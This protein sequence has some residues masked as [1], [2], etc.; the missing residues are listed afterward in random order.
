MSETF[1]IPVR[2][3]IE[4]TDVGGIVYYVNYLK[5]M[6]RARTEL[7]RSLGYGK[8]AMPQAG[9]LMVV[10]SANIEYLKSAQLDDELQVTAHIARLGRA[11]VVFEQGVLRGEER[12]ATATVKVACIDAGSRKPTPLPKDMYANLKR[13]N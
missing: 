13:F 8:A 6:E 1:S 12:I 9:L 7:L 4:D 5:F 10:H 2:V 11:T 3:Y